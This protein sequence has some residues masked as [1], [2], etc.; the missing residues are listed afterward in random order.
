MAFVLT[1]LG[2]SLAV[3]IELFEALAIVLAVGATRRFRDA[4]AGAAMA[5]LAL[6]AL[7]A[8]VGP[9]LLAR[10]SL[11]GLRVVIG[12]M[13]LLFGLEWL[14]KSV[15]RLAGRRSPSSAFREYVEQREE[16]ERLELPPPG[17]P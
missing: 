12:V 16:L 7:A 11:D 17:R 4:L 15:L 2:A 6:A 8:I 9:V 5:A 14:R 13:L 3:A 1:L 10:I